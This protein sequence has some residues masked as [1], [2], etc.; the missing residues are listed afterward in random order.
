MASLDPPGKRG[1]SLSENK[2]MREAGFGAQGMMDASKH[3][4]IGEHLY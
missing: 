4:Q 3:R 1:G 2:P